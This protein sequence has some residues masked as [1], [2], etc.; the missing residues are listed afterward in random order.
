MAITRRLP[1]ILTEDD[2]LDRGKQLANAEHAYTQIEEQKRAATKDFKD[3]LDAIGG[4]IEEL[5]TAIRDKVETRDV[6]CAILADHTVMKK[7]LIR[8]DTGETVEAYEFSEAE[9]QGSLL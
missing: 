9:R 6:E 2:V 3:Q 5:S 8:S 4:R 1:C 7:L